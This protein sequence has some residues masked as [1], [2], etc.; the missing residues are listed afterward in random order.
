MNKKSK[1]ILVSVLS[2]FLLILLF[3][4]FIYLRP[5]KQECT[6]RDYYYTNSTFQNFLD[7]PS[8]RT[9]SNEKLHV[10]NVIY[11]N[12]Y[13]QES[14]DV[15]IQY[16]QVNEARSNQDEQSVLL[17]NSLREINSDLEID[18]EKYSK[19]YMD[20]E[21]GVV[22]YWLSSLYDFL[23]KTNTVEVTLTNWKILELESETQ[24]AEIS[25]VEKQLIL[26][27][28]LDW[29]MTGGYRE[30]QHPTPDA[31]IHALANGE[32]SIKISALPDETKI[33]TA[34]RRYAN[35]SEVFVMIEDETVL[36]D[37]LKFI[38]EDYEV[39]AQID[40][41]N[42]IDV[43]CKYVDTFV[44]NVNNCGE[45]CTS[46][47]GSAIT[48]ELTDRCSVNTLYDGFVDRYNNAISEE[49]KSE[50]TFA[51]IF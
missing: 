22:Q 1:I 36:N 42:E 2:T 17:P 15:R 34:V 16:T 40:V 4:T 51:N 7:S 12:G 23:G 20:F 24:D 5:F 30:D 47:L 33:N 37:I 13:T 6:E 32:L 3:V 49:G 45:S 9:C 21:S 29:F 19:I 44:G 14:K 38:K 50:K 31:Y 43:D 35:I 8:V 27:N 18:T 39:L 48:Q 28:S 41:E 10:E 26:K 46:V 25:S 11:V